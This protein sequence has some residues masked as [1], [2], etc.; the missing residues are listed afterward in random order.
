MGDVLS[1]TAGDFQ[2]PA[3]SGQN[4]RKDVEYRA[5]VPLRRWNKPFPVSQLF[6]TLPKHQS[7]VKA[8][9]YIAAMLEHPYMDTSICLRMAP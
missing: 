6:A 1:R 8:A 9:E 4:A 3:P 2:H 5:L 7:L